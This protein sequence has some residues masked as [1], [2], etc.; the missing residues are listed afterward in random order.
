MAT[1]IP[2]WRDIDQRVFETEIVAARK[3][4]VLKGLVANWP[5]VRKG[6]ESAAAVVDYLEVLNSGTQV[7]Y[8][9]CDARFKGRFSYNQ[10]MT[11]ENFSRLRG[12]FAD[13]LRLLLANADQPAPPAL[14]IQAL[15]VPKHLPELQV[16][17]ALDLPP[18]GTHP[19]IWIGTAGTVAP[20]YDCKD[21]IACVAA[22]R[23]RFVLFPPEQLENLYVGPLHSTP[24]GVPISLV[25]IASP[26]LARFPK[27]AQAYAAAQTAELEPG[28]GI[29]IPY[30]WWHG[31][32][33]LAPFNVLVNYWWNSLPRSDGPPYTSLMHAIL[34][35]AS[36]P[37]EHR[38]IWHA[39]FEH[40]V[41]H[42]HGDPALHIAP[43]GRGVLGEMTPAQLEQMMARLL[44]ILT[45]E[46]PAAQRPPPGSS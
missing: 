2:Q 3:P 1:D 46:R 30:M 5:L 31:V 7:E 6:R 14:S 8:L 36:L 41:F 4:V 26:D 43:E 45:A 16:H 27:F 25:D 33:S 38:N 24:Q 34:A 40:F 12:K 37:A 35:I 23:R 18:P 42:A 10:N 44:Q 39:H 17:N 21:N 22:G 11:G 15:S 28:D 32:Q 20:H 9:A 29:Y 19:S 13:V